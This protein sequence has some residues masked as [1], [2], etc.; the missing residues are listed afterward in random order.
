MMKQAQRREMTARRV[1]CKARRPT[2]KV[3]RKIPGTEFI[4]PQ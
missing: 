2:S 3:P 4:G 1:A